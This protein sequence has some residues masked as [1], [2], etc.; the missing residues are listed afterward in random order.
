M[1]VVNAQGHAPEPTRAI[2]ELRHS[3]LS[4]IEVTQPCQIASFCTGIIHYVI[5]ILSESFIQTSNLTQ[6]LNTIQKE[7][8]RTE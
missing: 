5:K 6:S 3:A 1:H 8:I 4:K 7:Q 2:K